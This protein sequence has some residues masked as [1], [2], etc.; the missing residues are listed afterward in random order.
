MASAGLT[1]GDAARQLYGDGSL[2]IPFHRTQ[3]ACR[4]RAEATQAQDSGFAVPTG[5]PAGKLSASF[6]PSAL[7]AAAFGPDILA[8]NPVVPHALAANPP[9][10]HALAANPTQQQKVGP[11]ARPFHETSQQERAPNMNSAAAALMQPVQQGLSDITSDGHNQQQMSPAEE[12]AA[13]ILLQLMQQDLTST[14]PDGTQPGPTEQQADGAVRSGAATSVQHFG[15]P[16]GSQDPAAPLES[17]MDVDMVASQH[18]VKKG[19]KRGAEAVDQ[20]SSKRIDIKVY[21]GLPMQ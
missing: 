20:P 3:L 18:V 17:T 15:Q 16:P 11:P 6:G 9:E 14:L 13:N 19:R 21:A 2:T 12:S 5:A 8:A 10:P 7:L 1:F 4:L